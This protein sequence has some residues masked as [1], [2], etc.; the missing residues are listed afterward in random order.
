M[1]TTSGQQPPSGE[2]MFGAGFLLWASEMLWA[3]HF[4]SSL[5]IKCGGL[6]EVKPT[7][8]LCTRQAGSSCN[9]VVCRGH[10]KT[11]NLSRLVYPSLMCGDSSSGGK[12]ENMAMGVHVCCAATIHLPYSALNLLCSLKE[13][14]D[15]SPATLEPVTQVT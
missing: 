12:L 11:G 9:L 14:L 13:V 8:L 7:Q 6:P 1:L 2:E 15:R 4:L 5:L 10:S 3:W